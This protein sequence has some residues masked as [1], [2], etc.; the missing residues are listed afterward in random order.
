MK[1]SKAGTW[2]TKPA[3]V[4]Q[5][6]VEFVDTLGAAMFTGLSV[7]TLATWRSRSCGPRYFKVG[8]AVRYAIVDLR[9]FVK[10][11][12]RNADSTDGDS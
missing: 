3:A 2:N 8:R 4:A 11:T 7:K 5:A 9:D 10:R 6:P 1:R 12:P